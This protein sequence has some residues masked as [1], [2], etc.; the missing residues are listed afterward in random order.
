LIRVLYV[1]FIPIWKIRFFRPCGGQ[2]NMALNERVD[3]EYVFFR[4]PSDV[5]VVISGQDHPF[6]GIDVTFLGWCGSC[7]FRPDPGLGIRP[8]P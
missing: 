3:L 5:A 7:S 2:R 6:S 4:V 8:F 1:F